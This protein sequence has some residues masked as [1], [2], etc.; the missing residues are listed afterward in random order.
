MYTAN[1]RATN[2]KVKNEKKKPK[3]KTDHQ[4]EIVGEEGLLCDVS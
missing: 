1:S 4:P 3:T 2:K